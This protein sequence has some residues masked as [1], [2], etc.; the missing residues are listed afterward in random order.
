MTVQGRVTWGDRYLNDR[1][2]LDAAAFVEQ[3]MYNYGS[4]QGNTTDGLI[5]NKFYNL[6]ASSGYVNASNEDPHYVK[7]YI[8]WEMT[9]GGS[10]SGGT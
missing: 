5:I 4:L 8:R 2:S 10:V 7:V 9:A 3:R 1:L 6:A